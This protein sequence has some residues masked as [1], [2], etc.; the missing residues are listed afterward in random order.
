MARG[1]TSSTSKRKK[2]DTG[3]IG[4]G[5]DPMTKDSLLKFYRDMLLIRRF[6]ERAGQLNGMG[7]LGGFSGQGD[8]RLHFGLGN[9]DGWVRVTVSW[10]GG[11]TESRV[12]RA[13]GYHELRQP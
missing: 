11:K 7:L 9:H 5:A 2:D 6:E 1:Q 3:V 12:L 8:P 4:G 13:D 10:Y